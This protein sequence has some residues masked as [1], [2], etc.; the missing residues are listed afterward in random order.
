MTIQYKVGIL[1]EESIQPGGNVFVKG[2]KVV[3]LGDKPDHNQRIKV[4]KYGS[5]LESG[6]VSIHKIKIA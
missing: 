5:Y 1:T 6:L 3:I 4:S 2:A